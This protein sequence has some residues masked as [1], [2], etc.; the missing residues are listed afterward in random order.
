MTEFCTTVIAYRS[1]VITKKWAKTI[2]K[3]HRYWFRAGRISIEK[4]LV[5]MTLYIHEPVIPNNGFPYEILLL[6]CWGHSRSS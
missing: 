6:E 1:L 5:V 2:I 3:L 4:R